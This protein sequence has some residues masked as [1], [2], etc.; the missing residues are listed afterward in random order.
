M[1]ENKLSKVLKNKFWQ[2][3]L[4]ESQIILKLI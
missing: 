1:K 2:L 3:D 4:N